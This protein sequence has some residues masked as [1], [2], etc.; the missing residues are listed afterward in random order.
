MVLEIGEFSFL[1]QRRDILNGATISL[2]ILWMDT[3][4][5]DERSE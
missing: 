5:H 1:S 4:T 2:L 3:T